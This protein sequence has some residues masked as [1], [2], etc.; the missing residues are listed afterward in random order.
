MYV[1]RAGIREEWK[2]EA[3]KYVLGGLGAF[4][5]F[6]ISEFTGEFI[7]RSFKISD[8]WKKFF[9]KAFMRVGFSVLFAGLSWMTSGLMSWIFFAMALGSVSGLFLDVFGLVQPGG[10]KGLAESLAVGSMSNETKTAPTVVFTPIPET[11]KKQEEQ[12][13]VVVEKTE[14]RESESE[15]S[16]TPPMSL[17]A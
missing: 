14:S 13:V 10:F 8:M 11:E 7:V 15:V 6:G 16:V 1:L 2:S 5:G 9:V 17:Y 4:G 3:E 12:G